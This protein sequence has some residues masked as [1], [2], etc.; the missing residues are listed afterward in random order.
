VADAEWRRLSYTVVSWHDASDRIHAVHPVLF[1]LE[2]A[3][4]SFSREGDVFCLHL[5]GA[6]HRIDLA[7][8]SLV[9]AH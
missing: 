1:S 8:G 9:L 2:P 6:T 5:N 4:A 7:E 3:E